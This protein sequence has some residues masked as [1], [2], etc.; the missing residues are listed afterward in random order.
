MG[1]WGP[2]P[3]LWRCSLPVRLTISWKNRVK[4][5][6]SNCRLFIY[7]SENT[8][9]MASQTIVPLPCCSHISGRSY[10]SPRHFPRVHT[11][12]DGDSGPRSPTWCLLSRANGSQGGRPWIAEFVLAGQLPRNRPQSRQAIVNTRVLNCPNVPTAGICLPSVVLTPT[13]PKNALEN[14]LEAR[15]W[16]PLL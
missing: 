15:C 7:S 14:V 4:K 1:N 13:T 12:S 8:C 10:S 5:W 9:N 6:L 16:G 2:L 11:S 3:R